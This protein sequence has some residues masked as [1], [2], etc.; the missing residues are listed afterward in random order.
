MTDHELGHQEPV[1]APASPHTVFHDA[2]F[3]ASGSPC[4]HA[5]SADRLCGGY[6]RRKARRAPLSAVAFLAS[7]MA[8]T[9]VRFI[10]IFVFRMTQDEFATVLGTTQGRI[11][12]WES[13]GRFPTMTVMDLV[14]THGKALCAAGDV[15]WS[16]A[17]FFEVPPLSEYPQVPA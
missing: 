11:S 14:R 5:H 7:P 15:P 17:W 1:S 13:Q 2:K 6:A 10:R 4:G 12:T 3:I 9:T 8:I 16:D